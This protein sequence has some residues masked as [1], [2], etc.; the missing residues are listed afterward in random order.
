MIL[1]CFEYIWCLSNKIH[2]S[3][4]PHI[5]NKIYISIIKIHFTK[6]KHVK[7]EKE[8]ERREREKG[9]EICNARAEG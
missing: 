1:I 6:V 8:R 5:Y 4:P 3:F 9:R 7:R 2:Q